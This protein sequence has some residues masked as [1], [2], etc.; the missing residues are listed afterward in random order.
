MH[1]KWYRHQEIFLLYVKKM[2]SLLV[3]SLKFLF[4]EIKP[5]IKL[6][7]AEGGSA[8]RAPH[9]TFF[10]TSMSLYE[11]YRQQDKF[12]L[13]ITVFQKETF[14]WNWERR[15]HTRQHYLDWTKEDEEKYSNLTISAIRV[16]GEY[17]SCDYEWGENL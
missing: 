10:F 1:S 3:K 14:E 2:N 15:S 11:K 5:P 12:P 9:F 6:V 13:R 7:L 4:K 8:E 17:N 16:T